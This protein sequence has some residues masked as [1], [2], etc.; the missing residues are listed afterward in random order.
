M[1]KFIEKK[2]FLNTNTAI[3][4][5]LMRTVR[6]LEAE[7]RQVPRGNVITGAKEDE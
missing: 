4:Q 3:M 5:Q 2:D 6:P 7:W 1:A